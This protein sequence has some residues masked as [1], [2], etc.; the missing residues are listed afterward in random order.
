MSIVGAT[1]RPVAPRR[2][3]RLRTTQGLTEEQIGVLFAVGT[4]VSPLSNSLL[5]FAADRLA[6][7][8]GPAA[9]LHVFSACIVWVT[10]VFSL[11]SVRWPGVSKFSVMLIC[12]V[13]IDSARPS[14]CS[15]MDAITVQSLP[16]RKRYGEERLYGAYSWAVV[17]VAL[18]AI[19]DKFGPRAMHVCIPFAALG[20]GVAVVSVGAPPVKQPPPPATSAEISSAAGA[21]L[22]SAAVPEGGSVRV[23]D[24]L[25][26]YVSSPSKVAFFVYAITLGFGMALVENLLFLYFHEQHASYF[27]CGLSVLVT[28]IFEIPLFSRSKDLLVRFGARGCLIIA[29]LCYSFRVVGYTLVPGGAWVLFFEPM[30]GVTIAFW[31]TAS[32]EVMASITPPS[33]AATGQSFLSNMR[34]LFGSALGNLFGGIIIA[35]YGEAVLYRGAAVLVGMGL[36]CYLSATGG[37]CRR[38]RPSEPGGTNVLGGTVAA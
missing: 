4:W 24:L 1:L 27:V 23:V 20:V 18:G 25:K 5:S 2:G 15:M 33:L 35:N 31:Q 16:D 10:V 8:R 37:C 30:H 13:L 11:Q 7:K 28:V 12:R 6:S 32:V 38:C 34:G 29:G 21:A 19:M 17:G 9:R 26:S 22:G 3:P 36:L 14:C